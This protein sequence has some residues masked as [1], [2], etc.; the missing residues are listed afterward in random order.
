MRKPYSQLI[1]GLVFIFFNINI[2]PIDI[3][4]NFLGY[5]FIASG[6]EGLAQVNLIY[7]KGIIP[8]VVLAFASFILIFYPINTSSENITPSNCW[9]LGISAA[10]SVLNLVIF[11][12]IC[13]GIHDESEKLANNDLMLSAKTRWNCMLYFTCFSLILTPFTLN[14]G[15]FIVGL[16][17]VISLI[18]LFLA[19]LIVLLLWKARDE[20]NKDISL[21]E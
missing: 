19:F 18:L 17:F 5:I 4:P 13:K 7:K 11:Y 1:W 6:L 9:M 15:Q 8:S 14:K 2:G 21:E 12:S 16:N 20:F 3:L 10:F